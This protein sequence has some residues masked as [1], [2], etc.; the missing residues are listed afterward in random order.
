MTVFTHVNMHKCTNIAR[1]PPRRSGLVQRV[2]RRG[3]RVACNAC[4]CSSV[5]VRSLLE[6]TCLKTISQSCYQHSGQLAFIRYCAIMIMSAFIFAV[7]E[8][9]VFSSQFVVLQFYRNNSTKRPHAAKPMCCMWEL[10]LQF[11]VFV[12]E[13]R[14]RTCI[15]IFLL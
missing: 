4:Q 15:L 9:C 14:F 3:F 2:W 8:Y 13:R 12:F 10:I 1:L 5:Q 11:K 6:P 7:G